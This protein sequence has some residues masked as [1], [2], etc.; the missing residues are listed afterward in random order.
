MT[1]FTIDFFEF[2][3]LVEAC[4]PKRPI[5]RTIFFQNVINKYYYQMTKDE[6]DKLFKWVQL[7][8]SFNPSEDED[9][10][11]FYARYCPDNQY[12]I[13]TMFDMDEECHFCFRMG[14]YFHTTITT[15]IVDKYITKIEKL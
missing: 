5:A 10:A 13:T 15:S 4:I 7:N 11:A 9:S 8:P 3:F 12:K 14:E 2:S 6:A 1:T